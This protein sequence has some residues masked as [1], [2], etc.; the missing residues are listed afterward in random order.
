MLPIMPN[1]YFRI[2]AS[3]VERFI[4]VLVKLFIII[5]VGVT[6]AKIIQA[7]GISIPCPFRT[8]T[9]FKCPGC[10]IT[11]MC[12]AILAKDFRAAWSAN[13]ILAAISPAI[14][15]LFAKRTIAWVVFGKRK[16]SKTDRSI[17]NA[18]VIILVSWG[19]IRNIIGV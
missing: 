12:M 18:L 1:P 19:I 17:A 13:P 7:T 4:G 2:T 8:I 9:G 11:H 5:A 16:M 6:Y 10:G 14:A 15:Y 3:Q